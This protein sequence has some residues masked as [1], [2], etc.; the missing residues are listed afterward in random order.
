M[1]DT[2]A[3]AALEELSKS[4]TGLVLSDII[5]AMRSTKLGKLSGVSI[6]R[7]V[8]PVGVRLRCEFES[9]K[10]PSVEFEISGD[11]ALGLAKEMELLLPDT[12][13][14]KPKRSTS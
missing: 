14:R 11:L 6:A 5:T 8:K 12:Q 1:A 10:H 4:E 2:T 7:I 9:A 3:R 13:R